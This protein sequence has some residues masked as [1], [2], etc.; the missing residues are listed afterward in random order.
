[1]TKRP[2]TFGVLTTLAL[3]VIGCSSG[4]GAGEAPTELT[5]SSFPTP[6]R[7]FS[8]QG[9]GGNCLD[10]YGA[11]PTSTIVDNGACNGTNAQLFS[12]NND[13]TITNYWGYCL[14]VFGNN[15]SQGKLDFTTCNG[16][17]AQQW[18][19]H[20]TQVIGP[21]GKCLDVL[22]N[23]PTPGQTVDLASCNGT[24]A[25][26]WQVINA[27]TALQSVGSKCL[28]IINSSTSPGARLQI[29]ECNHGPNAQVFTFSAK[30]EIKNAVG[31]CLDV[32]Y[33]NAAGG[34]VQM[35]NCNGTAAQKWTRVGRQIRSSLANRQSPT[36]LSTVHDF[37]AGA[38]ELESSVDHTAV[39][40]VTCDGR[41]AQQ[42]VAADLFGPQAGSAYAGEA[43]TLLIVTSDAFASTFA[44]FVQHKEAIGVPTKLLT[45]SQIRAAYP[46]SDDVLA[47]KQAIEDNYRSFGT[48]Y[49]LLGGDGSQVPLRYREVH[50][51]GGGLTNSFVNSDLY[52]ANLYH[53]HAPGLGTLAGMSFD[54]WDANGNGLFDELFW[55]NGSLNPD[56]VDGFP[57][58]AVGRLPAW[59]TTVL[60]AL[61]GK[62]VTF[63][64]SHRAYG[65]PGDPNANRFLV[66][67]DA[68]YSG[69][70]GIAQTVMSKVPL[71]NTLIPQAE[72]TVGN[73]PSNHAPQPDV[74]PAGWNSDNAAWGGFQSEASAGPEWILYVGHGPGDNQGIVTTNSFWGDEA[75]WTDSQVSQLTNKTPSIVTAVACRTGGF[76]T[77]YKQ[78]S[79]TFGPP[80]YD[81]YGTSQSDIGSRWLFDNAVG[82]AVAYLGE[83]VV[84]PD[85]A[86]FPSDMFAAQQNGFQRIGDIYRM[87]QQ[88]YFDANS[89]STDVLSAPRFY[90]GTMTLLG[91]PSMRTQ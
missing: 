72:E 24:G 78:V 50:D 28:D 25:Q 3:A 17:S 39:G 89:T 87:A 1:M 13:G 38:A 68:C 23:N 20:G 45:M 63:E 15:T 14:D 52:Y 11:N 27:P 80:I 30:G 81:P 21:A 22:G 86:D 46:S 90:N 54:N 82:G 51:G 48:R 62:I 65:G 10:V 75:S 66:A 34:Q 2:I 64:N 6:I 57:D 31:E 91:D 32:L 16:T 12:F 55:D 60:A 26:V 49:V 43:A 77:L 67:A 41:E 71:M 19:L 76:A 7:W 9:T 4:P 70:Y 37:N 58:V 40:L 18:Q 44:G 85:F 84:M 88:S 61:L 42:W 5:R 35:T 79:T 74:P 73:C 69:S 83:N 56:N 47:V 53:G 36:C 8:L 59:N 33:G 29:F